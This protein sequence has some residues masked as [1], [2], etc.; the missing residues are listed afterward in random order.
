MLNIS[1]RIFG[2]GVIGAFYAMFSTLRAKYTSDRS[3]DAARFCWHNR[4]LRL[5]DPMITRFDAR[6]VVDGLQQGGFALSR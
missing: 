3:A 6:A 5:F 2:N 4:E 1:R